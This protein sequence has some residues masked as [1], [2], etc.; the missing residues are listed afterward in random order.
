MTTVQVKCE[1][2]RKLA[3]IEASDVATEIIRRTC[4]CCNVYQIKIEP[5]KFKL[6]MLHFIEYRRIGCTKKLMDALRNLGR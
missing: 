6:G 5:R 3:K 4:R 1:C 2:G